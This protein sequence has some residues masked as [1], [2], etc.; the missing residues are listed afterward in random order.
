MSSSSNI[1]QL[2]EDVP[3]DDSISPDAFFW[4][5]GRWHV[6][7]SRNGGTRVLPAGIGRVLLRLQA[8]RKLIEGPPG[9][10]R[11]QPGAA[12]PIID[13]LESPLLRLAA[14]RKEDGTPYLD[15]D[16]ISA[17]ERMRRDFEASGLSQRVTV[18]YGDTAGSGGRHW[19]SS[20]NATARLTDAAL[21]ARQRLH[22]AMDAVGPE[23]SG[24]LFD[25][26]CMASGLEHAEMRLALP[27]RA[28]KAVLLLAL[29]RL[30]RHYGLKSS[31]KHG[32][33]S[34]IGHWALSDF[35]P[36]MDQQRSAPHRP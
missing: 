33:P 1:K 12:G 35:R 10:F 31:M 8:D 36:G 7:A 16:L 30:A 20:D 15:D 32:G 21:A 26:C 22:L 23:L 29:T 6:A 4:R 11:L 28:G 18:V 13:D 19:Q 5:N 9:V 2:H 17:G 14:A 34:H 3:L 27:R 24:I 25:V